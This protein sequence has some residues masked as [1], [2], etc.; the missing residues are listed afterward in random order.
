MAKEDYKGIWVFAEQEHG[1][2]HPTVFELLAKAGELKA[3][4]GETVTA[5]LLGSGVRPL[6]QE[7]FDRGADEV[8]LAENDALAEYSARPYQT[9][10]TQLAER[11]LPSIVLFGA[12]PLGR[13]LA[14][15]VM[16][17]LDTGLTADAIDLSFDEDGVF[18]QT[19]PAY[20]GKILAHIAIPERRPQMVTVHPQIC[21]PKE[22]VPGSA[23]V[24]HE[25]SVKVSPD[26][27]YVV[28]ETARAEGAD[29]AIDAAP[30]IVAGGRGIKSQEDL[31]MLREL[32]E[33]LG[34]QLA[35][36]RP[37]VDCGWLEHD[38]Q[39]GQSGVT[40]APKVMINVAISGSVQ[41]Q[42]GM[43]NS[44]CIVAVNKAADAPIFD[45]A[46]FGVVD[47]YRNFIPALIEELK[48]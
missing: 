42:L 7:L 11:H 32:A 44:E 20:G 48:S 1:A 33:L 34:G 26:P 46:H 4:C 43:R 23:G 22:P 45:I 18:C 6:V 17:S 15:R 39:I 35:S 14:P 38:K 5:V 2:L 24:L 36:S 13:D 21:R 25:E 40:V 47:D 37:L 27:D 41:Y 30:A 10:L 9:A 8:I 16:V 28:V 12:T 29:E 19:T 3:V 31:A